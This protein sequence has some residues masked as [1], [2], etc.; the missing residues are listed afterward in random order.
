MQAA[1]GVL[2]FEKIDS[3][4]R[5]NGLP[6]HPD[7]LTPGA[8][9][10]TGSLG[11]GISKAKG[12]VF[13]DRLTGKQRRNIYVMTGDGELQEGQIWESLLSAAND[14]MGEITVIVDHNKVQSDISVSKVSDLGDLEKKFSSFGWEVRRSD[15]HN[16]FDLEKVF[17]EFDVITDRP[18]VLIADTIKGYGVQFMQHTSMRPDEEYY[19][20]HSGAPSVAEYSVAISDLRK[21]IDALSVELQLKLPEPRKVEVEPLVAPINSKRLIPAYTEAL[22]EQAAQNPKLIALDADLVLDTGLI[23]FKNRFPDRFIECGIAEQDMVSRA[24][25]IALSGFI[26][27]VH[28]F[29]CFLTSRPN[30]QIYNSATERSKV[31]Y[32]GSLA[33]LLPGGPGHSHQAVRDIAALSGLPGMVM[34]EPAT[35]RQV[36]QAL[37]WCIS[38]AKGPTYLRL[39]SI[40][41]EDRE[42][43]ESSTDLIY[44]RGYVLM[45]GCDIALISYGPVM[46]VEILKAA[47]LLS[48]KGVSAKVINH[49]WLNAVDKDWL[50]PLLAGLRATVTI[51]NHYIHGGQGQYLRAEMCGVL[52]AGHRVVSLG[53]SEIPVC[54]RNDEVLRHHNLDAKGIAETVISSL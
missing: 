47:E 20:Y 40:P 21:D 18:K 54:G 8:W 29:A 49:P 32:V 42:D 13:A 9:T 28:S 52:P 3:L 33:G 48:K 46:L 11:M 31:I 19:R 4:R 38:Q 27:I 53:V 2:P 50:L 26:P 34:I 25:A 41:Y 6:G 43:L 24:G 5:Y 10:N 45:D 35:P 37:S 30:E 17:T 44:G 12:F 23:P 22:L 36:S 16:Y 39:A 51:D 1:L 15:G 14:K 7:V